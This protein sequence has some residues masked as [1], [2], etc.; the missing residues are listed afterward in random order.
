MIVAWGLVYVLHVCELGQTNSFQL[1]AF[2]LTKTVD[3]TRETFISNNGQEQETVQWHRVNAS[4]NDT[5]SR[6][7]QA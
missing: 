5:I 2:S 1:S 7:Q 6:Q 4:F 3:A